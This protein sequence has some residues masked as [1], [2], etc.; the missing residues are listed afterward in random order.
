MCESVNFI[1]NTAHSNVN[2][3]D[4]YVFI[5]PLGFLMFPLIFV[6][7]NIYSVKG[8]INILGCKINPSWNTI[9]NVSVFKFDLTFDFGKLR[10][11]LF[12]G[13]LPLSI[14]VLRYKMFYSLAVVLFSVPIIKVTKYCYPLCS[15]CPL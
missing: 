6:Q 4:F 8:I 7:I 13:A 2:F 1:I 12:D 3:I 10:N 9:N 14:L 15:W 11:I 5:L